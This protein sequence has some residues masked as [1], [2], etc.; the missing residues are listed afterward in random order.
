MSTGLWITR[1][2]S[3]V[4]QADACTTSP[5]GDPERGT[6]SGTPGATP[7]RPLPSPIADRSVGV[8][9]EGSA[10]P[11]PVDAVASDAW[12]SQLHDFDQV[13]L[14]ELR[15]SRGYSQIRVC[16]SNMYRP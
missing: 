6:I 16:P 15:A 11:T 4:T 5:G 9:K 12:P 3:L 1:S 2:L 10:V 13:D 8:L 7:I 14:L